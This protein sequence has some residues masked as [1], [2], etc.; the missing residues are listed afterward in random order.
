MTKT[1]YQ[2]YSND[3]VV[4]HRGAMEAMLQSGI[5][6]SNFYGSMFMVM[7]IALPQIS[8]HIFCYK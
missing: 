3:L 1:E 7:V 6:W 5:P 8:R 4:E 2:L